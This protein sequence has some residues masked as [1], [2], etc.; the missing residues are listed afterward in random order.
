MITIIITIIII[1]IITKRTTNSNSATATDSK[2]SLGDSEKISLQ[3]LLDVLAYGDEVI[4]S[5]LKI[6]IYTFNQ[7]IKFLLHM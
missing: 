4:S 3:I 2:T 5:V 6:H 1:I 7:L